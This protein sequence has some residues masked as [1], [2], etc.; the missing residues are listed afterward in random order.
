MI[1]C[2]FSMATFSPPAVNVPQYTTFFEFCVILMKPPQPTARPLNL[3]TFTLPIAAEV[4][5]IGNVNVSK[6]K[7]RAV[8]CGGFI[9]ITQNSKKVVYCGTFTAGGLKVAIENGQLII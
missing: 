1:S 5:A 2:P 3:L 7:G 4:D 6:V 8:G 9:N